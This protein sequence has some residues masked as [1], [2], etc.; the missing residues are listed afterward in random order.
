MELYNGA[1][2]TITI[3]KQLL[4]RGDLVV[5]PRKEYEELLHARKIEEFYAELDK[6]L[7]RA[8]A[9]HRRG[10]SI[11]PFTSVAQLKKSLSK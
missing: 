2:Q 7:D 6:D 4:R 11:G 5:I 10:E 3:P 1:M 9:S 8:I